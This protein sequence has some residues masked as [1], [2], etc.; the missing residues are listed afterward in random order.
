[1][2]LDSFKL[3]EALYYVNV[4]EWA[5]SCME[6]SA[7]AGRNVA[8]LAYNDFLQKHNLVLKKEVSGD[9]IEKLRMAGEL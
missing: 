7:I 4:I 9:S 2:N 1:M 6:M 3:H 8:I 5:A